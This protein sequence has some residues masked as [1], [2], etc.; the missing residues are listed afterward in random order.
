MF[1][2][3]QHDWVCTQ[4]TSLE[5]YIW[6]YKIQVYKLS[7][8]MCTVYCLIVSQNLIIHVTM[9]E[10][11]LSTCIKYFKRHMAGGFFLHTVTVYTI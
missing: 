10:I 8:S 7:S 6:M 2:M 3:R 1:E 4:K 5:W 9:V 11:Q